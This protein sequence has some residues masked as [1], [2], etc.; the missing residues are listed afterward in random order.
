M[1]LPEDQAQKL[2]E[3]IESALDDFLDPL[4][5]S[6]SKQIFEVLLER[7]FSRDSLLIGVQEA[8]AQS[9]PESERELFINRFEVFRSEL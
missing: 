8:I 4:A 5:V 3:T 7:G 9:V 1:S 2:A 6:I